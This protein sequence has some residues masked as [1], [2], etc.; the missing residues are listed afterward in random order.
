MLRIVSLIASATETVYALG[1]GDYLVG[2]SHECDYPDDVKYLPCCTA[3]NFETAAAS[4]AVDDDVKALLAKALSV[5]SVDVKKLE[6]LKPTHIIT[7][8]QC[9]VCAVSLSDL[10]KACSDSI[11]SR[12]QIISLNPNSLADISDDISKIGTACGVA[13]QSN[14]LIAALDK[15]MNAVATIASYLKPV[16]VACIEWLDPLMAAGNWMPELVQL[17]GGRNLFGVAAQHAP[18]LT[19]ESLRASDPEVIVV[20]PCGFD[21]ERTLSEMHLLSEQLGF[22]QMTAAIYEHIYI[23]DGNQFFNRPGPRIAES[24]EMMAEMLHPESFDFG[25]EDKNWLRFPS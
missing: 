16:S 25:H 22:E 18:A 21:I 24:L 2:R 10:Q 8:D 4:K 6:E 14:Q 12:P 7:Q 9:Q 19:W 23:A 11:S 15:R 17:A 3:P 20:M 13:V 1:L 5:Y